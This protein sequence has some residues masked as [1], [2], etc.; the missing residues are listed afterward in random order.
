MDVSQVPPNE[1]PVNTVFQSYALFPHLNVFENVAFSLRIKKLDP[2]LIKQK[3]EHFIEL[4]KLSEHIYKMPNQLSGGQRQRVSIARALINEPQVLLLDEPLSALDAKLRHQLLVDL[5]KLH[6][7]V[8]ITFIYVTHDQQEALGVSDR[9]AI[10]NKGRILQVA[11]AHEIYDEPADAF[12]AQFIGETNLFH[13][14]LESTNGKVSTIA[15]EQVG[16]IRVL[17][18]LPL[19]SQSKVVVSLRP[20]KIALHHQLPAH[21]S[22]PVLQ[23]TVEEIV[24]AG[25]QSRVYVNVNGFVLKVQQPH[26][27]GAVKDH[28]SWKETVYVSWDDAACYLVEANAA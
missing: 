6:D 1:R 24:Y 8:G 15:T 4:V 18:T 9:I 28:F 26:V 14:Q 22:G 23:G 10:M 12:V 3:V 7:E 5:D 27:V 17:S 11:T 13:G 16:A 19:T 20:E 21:S 2:T 25:Y